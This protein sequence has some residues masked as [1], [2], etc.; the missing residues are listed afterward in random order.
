MV[1]V[2]G[3]Y[4]ILCNK[5]MMWWNFALLI[6]YITPVKTGIFNSRYYKGDGF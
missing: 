1:C 3:M 4:Y 2:C 6:V 5:N